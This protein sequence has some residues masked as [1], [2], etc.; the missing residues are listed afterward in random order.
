MW[1]LAFTSLWALGHPYIYMR[2]Y[3]ILSLSHCSMRRCCACDPRL[4]KGQQKPQR[5]W[6]P[7]AVWL[8][9]AELGVMWALCVGQSQHSAWLCILP[10]MALSMGMDV[11]ST[12]QQLKVV[13]ANSCKV[14]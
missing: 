7:E 6:S 14:H 5:A 9:P 4:P 13:S 8:R 3:C 12:T 10:L 2:T 11:K 1:E